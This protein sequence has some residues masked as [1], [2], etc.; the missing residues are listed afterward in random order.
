MKTTL[1]LM[2]GLFGSLCAAQGVGGTAGFGGKAGFGG[3][4][5]AFPATTHEASCTNIGTTSPLACSASM[6]V[7]AGD[8]IDCTVFQFTFG[9]AGFT[10]ADATNGQYIPPIGGFYNAD[11]AHLGVNWMFYNS[12]AATITPTATIA[13]FSSVS[14]FAIACDAYKGASTTLP[15][16]HSFVLSS[17]SGASSTANPTAGSA[18]IPSNAGEVIN[19]GMANINASTPTAGTNYTLGTR[20]TGTNIT[21]TPE[22]WI[23]TTATSTNC[24]YTQVSDVWDDLGV[25]ILNAGATASG[26]APFPSF[27]IP[28][29][30]ITTGTV[31]TAG[32]TY[33]GN[34]N[35]ATAT[36]NPGLGTWAACTNTDTVLTISS[37]FTPPSLLTPF[38]LNGAL[39]SGN[40]GL[41]LDEATKTPTGTDSCT[42]NFS[43]NPAQTVSESGYF[44]ITVPNTD[45][46]T[47]YPFNQLQGV[48]NRCTPHITGDGTHLYVGVE[49]NGTNG[50]TAPFGPQITSSTWFG[51]EIVFSSTACTIHVYNTSGAE[52]ANS[53]IACL[54]TGT[55]GSANVCGTGNNGTGSAVLWTG[56]QPNGIE[57]GNS[58]AEAQTT[59]FNLLFSNVIVDMNGGLHL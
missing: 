54:S 38:Y 20:R 35:G 23:Q 46:S 7:S 18:V 17:N 11:T 48:T 36:V 3:G 19:C 40:S 58:G 21:S 2:L 34:M 22:F 25:G 9:T 50:F 56:A 8:T 10:V 45:T 49:T 28:L 31:P 59:G 15:L 37:A 6:T 55:I 51:Y 4:F 13:S 53:P 57:Y 12:A 1:V 43:S 44:E 47:Q 32:S 41:V 27:F 29:T 39:Q 42:F 16:D 52:L 33:S 30:G 24:P 5:V 26:Y 14:R